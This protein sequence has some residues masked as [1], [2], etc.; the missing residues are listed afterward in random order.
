MMMGFMYMMYFTIGTVII[1]FCSL[2]YQ[3]PFMFLAFYFIS[4]FIFV[5]HCILLRFITKFWV[6]DY[7]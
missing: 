1:H 5:T 4:F 7:L 2:P 6:R 3:I